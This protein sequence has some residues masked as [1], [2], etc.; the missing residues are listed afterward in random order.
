MVNAMERRLFMKKVVCIIITLLVILAVLVGWKLNNST[1]SITTDRNSYSPAMSSTRG[2]NLK[3]N[4]KSK[5]VYKNLEYH[6]TTEEGSFLIG[7]NNDVKEVRNQGQP[8]LWS[9]IQSDTVVNIKSSFKVH[10]EVIDADNKKV[11]AK[12]NLVIV[13]NNSFYEIKK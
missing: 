12:N 9:A 2:I 5:K 3:P 1:V 4:L 11:I 10:L 7:S 6:W 13:P 8:V